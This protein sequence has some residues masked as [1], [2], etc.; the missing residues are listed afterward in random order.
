MKK[1]RKKQEKK[2]SDIANKILKQM[3][4]GGLKTQNGGPTAQNRRDEKWKANF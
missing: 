2:Q 3:K 1:T 4:I